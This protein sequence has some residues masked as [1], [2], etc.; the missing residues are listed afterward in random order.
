MEEDSYT[1]ISLEAVR[2]YLEHNSG[3]VRQVDIVNHFRSELTGSA[4]RTC[5][6]QQFKDV[7]K[8][9]S[10]VKIENG[11]K[12]IILTKPNQDCFQKS[13]ITRKSKR[14]RRCSERQEIN[15]NKLDAMAQTHSSSNLSK[16]PEQVTMMSIMNSSSRNRSFSND[17]TSPF[18]STTSLNVDKRLSKT[19]IDT[20]DSGTFSL[21]SDDE[22]LEEEMGL[23]NFKPITVLEKEWFV[24]SS[25]G[26]IKK[27]KTLYEES[28]QLLNSK[29]FVLG[30]TA[31]HWAAK[32]N[33]TDLLDFVTAR[34]GDIEATSHGGST[35]LHVAAMSGKEDI[36]VRLLNLDANISARDH[37]G[38]KPKDVVKDT[39][40]ENI[41]R[42]LGKIVVEQQNS[43]QSN[44]TITLNRN[45][46][47]RRTSLAFFRR[48]SR[49][50]DAEDTDGL[51]RGL[52]TLHR[53]MT[54]LRNRMTSPLA[55]GRRFSE[56]HSFEGV[57]GP[58]NRSGNLETRLRSVTDVGDIAETFQSAE[59][60]M[61]I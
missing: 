50:L 4:D 33:R 36:I 7:L 47:L 13:L 52:D 59:Y 15:R 23:N 12:Y 55:P 32:L 24:A 51:Q 35:P 54:L 27:L 16:S 5:A 19:S 44:P 28:N 45:S 46:K 10:A 22:E 14:F 40:S 1:Q 57:R 53:S 56:V 42:R 38:R 8:V 25:K 26:E 2:G 6:R 48:E 41:Q 37:G 18:Q 39:V 60:S 17:S 20:T 43:I 58:G 49:A 34:N 3:K 11:E 31:L 29:D 9:I 61:M 21:H 30:Y